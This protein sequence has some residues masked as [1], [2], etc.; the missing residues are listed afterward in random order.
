MPSD[1]HLLDRTLAFS[2]SYVSDDGHVR[3]RRSSHSSEYSGSRFIGY[4]DV[5]SRAGHSSGTGGH[6]PD[7][8]AAAQFVAA[9]G[10]GDVD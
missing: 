8:R 5:C 6:L 4:C 9:H 3:I 7:V 2:G 1:D 10:H